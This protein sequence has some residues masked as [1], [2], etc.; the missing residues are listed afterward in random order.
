VIAV[1]CD[2][3]SIHHARTVTVYLEEHPRLE[4]LYGARYSPHDNPV[5]RV[6]E[7]LK[8]YVANTA[9][10]WPG[11]LRQIRSFFRARSPDQMLATAAP[12]TSPWDDAEVDIASR[13]GACR[14]RWDLKGGSRLGGGFRSDV[15][16]CSA[17][18][19]EQVVVKLTA[20]PEEA[21]LEAAALASWA[22]TG[23]AARLIDADISY[24]ALLLERIRPGTPL[25]GGD[26]PVSVEVA[27]GL[28]ARLHLAA[29]GELGFPALEDIYL[30]LESQP[31]DDADFEQRTRGDPARGAAGLERLEM[32]R[33]AAM[34]LCAT[35]G[36]AVLLHGDFLDKNLLRSGAGYVA[37]DPIPRIG[38]PCADAGFFAAC[39]P[40]ATTILQR[41]G[42]V[43]EHMGLDR[44]RALR[45]AAVWAVLQACQAWR[46]DQS[47][48]EACLSSEQF[49]HLLAP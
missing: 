46:E 39:H 18:D 12:W 25:P 2:N 3:D 13:L 24:G 21:R 31:R 32:A 28:L 38:D 7:A 30:R 27:A 48:L 45:W 14:R 20:T 29:H 23:A 37:I 1:I 10:T 26:D 47:D 9:V 6:W 43:A 35:T 36:R 8:N 15:F 22:R 40:P 42:A 5:E 16:A 4:L 17:A 33:A 41:A 49:E 19:G 44:R 11:R 34:N